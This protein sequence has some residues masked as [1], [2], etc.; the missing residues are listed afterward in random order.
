[1]QAN[2]ANIL[3]SQVA[4]GCTYTSQN[5]TWLAHYISLHFHH[6]CYLPQ[7]HAR[8]KALTEFQNRGLA[9]GTRFQRYVVSNA[10]F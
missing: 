1:M 7:N 3:T 6:T 10:S 4:F 2:S 9:I 5:R 8:C